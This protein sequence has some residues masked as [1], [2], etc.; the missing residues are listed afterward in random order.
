[1]ELL[2][3]NVKYNFL[4]VSFINNSVISSNNN[5][6]DILSQLFRPYLHS[7]MLRTYINK[8][9]CG[10][11]LDA[12]GEWVLL[13]HSWCWGAFETRGWTAEIGG[14]LWYSHHVFEGN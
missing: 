7:D 6:F 3:I 13:E 11:G 14:V 9:Y 12:G 8:H 1:M 4:N 2:I 5:S 10:F